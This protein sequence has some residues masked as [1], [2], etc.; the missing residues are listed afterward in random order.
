MDELRPLFPEVLRNDTG[1]YLG[2]WWGSTAQCLV[3]IGRVTE[4]YAMATQVTPFW[5]VDAIM[6]FVG[7]AAKNFLADA[8]HAI[9]ATSLVRGLPDDAWQA[10]ST[11][12]IVYA[13][14][15]HH[16]QLLAVHETELHIWLRYSAD[17]RAELKPILLGLERETD[18][19]K[20]VRPLDI[21]SDFAL[22]SLLWHEG[23][24]AEL[25]ASLDRF[26]TLIEEGEAI[27]Q[28]DARAM[29]AQLI[30]SQGD[31]AGAWDIIRMTV[32]RG[33]HTEPGDCHFF[34]AMRVIETAATLALDAGDRDVARSWIEMHARWLEWSGSFVGQVEQ[35]LLRSR[36]HAMSG[37]LSAAEAGAR[38]A[39]AL[40]S[41]PRQPL[42]LIAVH[43]F[44][45]QLATED[46]DAP[47]AAQ[48]LA[49]SLDLAD[50]CRAPFERALTLLAFAELDAARGNADAARSTLAEVR[51]ICEPLEARP[52]LERVAALERRIGGLAG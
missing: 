40:A 41:E 21:P 36:L 33:P 6:S 11:A 4:G 16:R 20:G 27:E 17:Q 24:W 35:A 14:F 50:A 7:F 39:L 25:R 18:A 15:G 12:R 9:A 48:H 51:A 42:A 46:G 49:Q 1:G 45:G 43:R 47:L 2:L 44:L 23:R 13:S 52:T 37:D 5:S 28:E 22:R 38:Q 30:A 26:V 19:A 10:A 3:N 8:W 34:P 31:I 32:P 29:L